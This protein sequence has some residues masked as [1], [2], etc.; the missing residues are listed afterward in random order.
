MR[1]LLAPLTP[2]Y[3]LGVAARE[4]AYRRGWARVERLARP[5]VSVGSLSVGGAGKTP[6]VIRLAELL[7]GAGI[8]VDVL[9][10]GYGRLHSET[11]VVDP[12]GSAQ[13]F[14]DEPLLI[15]RRTGVPVVVGASRFEAG[16]LAEGRVAAGAALH[17]LDD[18]FQHRQLARDAD[19]VLV[20]RA[21]IEDSLLPGGN[22]REPLSALGRATF[23]VVRED[24]PEVEGELRRRGRLQP[25]WRVRR[26]LE[27]P[28]GVSGCIA[29]C[30]IARP[31]DFFAGLRAEG[32]A[33]AAE[34]GFRDHHAYREA[35]LRALARLAA[36]TK[37]GSFVTTEKDLVRLDGSQKAVLEAVAPIRAVRLR[38]SFAEEPGVLS[39]LLGIL[40]R[41]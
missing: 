16:L 22:L 30:G 35:D 7:A 8:A 36:E 21:D 20:S 38:V 18:G 19:V 13:R 33:P 3:A 26:E 10:R 24:E 29:F 12:G 23:L 4:V 25:V 9:S 15:A 28:A 39:C 5:V 27:V 41:L 11:E 14:G 40:K 37:A 2:L 17:L 34:R 6:V 32:V 31:A 1:P